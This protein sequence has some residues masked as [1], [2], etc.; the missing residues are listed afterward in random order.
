MTRVVGVEPFVVYASEEIPPSV[1]LA[2]YVL[3]DSDGVAYV[4]ETKEMDR[5]LR[6]QRASKKVT[7]DSRVFVCPV[8]AK[9]DGLRYETALIKAAE[10]EGIALVSY[11]D[12]AHRC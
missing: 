12:G 11:N 8:T 9:G 3:L 4:G 6:E 10:A 7:S 1:A 5:R 2:V